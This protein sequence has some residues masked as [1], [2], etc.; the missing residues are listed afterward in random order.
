MAP[1]AFFPTYWDIC[2]IDAYEESTAHYSKPL[3]YVY[4]SYYYFCVHLLVI[5]VVLSL[6]DLYHNVKLY[7]QRISSYNLKFKP[8]WSI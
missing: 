5:F 2:L 6:N 8:L 1:G 7:D 4:S 3:M